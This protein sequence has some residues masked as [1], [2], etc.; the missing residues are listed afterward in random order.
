MQNITVLDYDEIPWKERERLRS[1]YH[2]YH[3][4]AWWTPMRRQRQPHESFWARLDIQDIYY[5]GGFGE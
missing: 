4:D 1:C 5:V 2:R 3:P